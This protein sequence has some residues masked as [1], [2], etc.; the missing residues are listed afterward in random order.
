MQYVDLGGVRVSRV[1]LGSVQFGLAYGIANKLGQV[2]YR[3]LLGILEAASEAGVNFIDTSRAYGT[4][5]EVL[6]RALSELGL[7]RDFLLCSKLDLPGGYEELSDGALLAEARKSLYTSLDALGLDCLPFYLLHNEQYLYFRDGILWRFMLDEAAKGRVSRAGVSIAVGPD[8][9]LACMRAPG[10]K[11][12]QIPFNALDARWEEG[13]V[14]KA[15][16]AGGVA[17]F[18]RSSYLQGLLGMEIDEGAA[19]LP[20]SRPYLERLAAIARDEG[21]PAR[22]FAFK[23]ALWT[24]GIASTVVGVDSEAQLA[25]NLSLYRSGNVSESAR[26]RVS[27]ALTGV[28]VEVV[29]PALWSK[30]A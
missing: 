8:D 4:S 12:I 27:E 26:A 20:A 6:G 29:N 18:T 5:E 7:K 16:A 2:S 30:P 24:T 28:P 11:A 19:R 9:A 23:Y 10:L 17:V 14:L 15:A 25:E 1:G 13:G 3:E 22:D 21:L